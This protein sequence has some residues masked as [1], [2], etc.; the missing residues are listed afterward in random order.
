M[1]I[2]NSRA[3][4]LFYACLALETGSVNAAEKI[5]ATG[6]P[7]S[8][9]LND[10]KPLSEAAQLKIF[11]RDGFVDR[12]T[13]QKVFLPPVLTVLSEMLPDVFPNHPNWKRDET[14]Q[15]HEM[16]T[17]TVKKIIPNRPADEFNLA[18]AAYKT[19]AAKAN[20]TLEDLGWKILSLEEIADLRWNGMTGWFMN[21]VDDHRD[22]LSVPL[23]ARWYKAIQNSAQ[24][25]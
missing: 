10:E 16:F 6:F 22:L 14:H 4:A 1:A 24:D 11:R 19:K 9:Y 20:A 5:I 18:T 7:F 23:I 8:G 3:D 13:G 15:A 2:D 17:A 12:F 21:Y 25:S